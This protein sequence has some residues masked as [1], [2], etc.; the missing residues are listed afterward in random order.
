MLN[1][2]LEQSSIFAMLSTEE[3]RQRLIGFLCQS[4]CPVEDRAACTRRP[5]RTFACIAAQVL[6]HPCSFR[7]TPATPERSAFSVPQ[8]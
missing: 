2:Y 5:S 8:T 7:G 1:G 6:D 4:R 3:I